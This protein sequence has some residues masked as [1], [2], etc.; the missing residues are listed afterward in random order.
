MLGVA[1]SE[2]PREQVEYR[3]RAVEDLELPPESFDLVVASL[4]V[5]YGADH[6]PLVRDVTGLLKPG[7]HFVYSVEHLTKTASKDP[8]KAWVR[9]GEGNALYWPLSDY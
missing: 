2:R 4:C 6:A 5:H 3:L 1:R 9:D 7:G 8:D